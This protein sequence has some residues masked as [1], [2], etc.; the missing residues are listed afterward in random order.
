MER[1]EGGRRHYSNRWTYRDYMFEV[2]DTNSQERQKKGK[3]VAGRRACTHTHTHTHTLWSAVE[4]GQES[5]S[6]EV[7]VTAAQ[8]TEGLW[9]LPEA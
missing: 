4:E 1:G 9:A 5:P 6:G 3:G 7:R 2:C 8:S